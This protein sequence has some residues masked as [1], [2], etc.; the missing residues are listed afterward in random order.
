MSAKEK[1]TVLRTIRL[2]KELDDALQKDA[3]ENDTSVNTIIN[4]ALTKYVQWDR[5]ASK[6]GFVTLSAEAFKDILEQ[7][8][9][10]KII[11]IAT[12][13]GQSAPMRLSML[14]FKKTSLETAVKS[15]DLFS[16]YTG[17]G[18]AEFE[19]KSG[20]GII[21]IHHNLGIKW[22]VYLKH[23]LCAYVNTALKV[24]AECNMAEN[25][26]AIIFPLSSHQ[27]GIFNLPNTQHE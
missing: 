15:L 7:C 4:K 5:L 9:E 24:E 12:K 22:S 18:K 23:M 6:F 14:W 17:L 20:R 2:S 27:L 10:D 25:S 21:T 3:K 13:L 1:K 8:S 26:I 16:K 19:I 11:S